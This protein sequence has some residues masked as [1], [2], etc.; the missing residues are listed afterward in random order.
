VGKAV[1]AYERGL[2]SRRAPFDVFVEGLRTG[3]AAKMA[4]PAPDGARG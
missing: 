3:D 1:A 2:V 4:A